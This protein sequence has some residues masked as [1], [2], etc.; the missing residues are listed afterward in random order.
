MT[1]TKEVLMNWKV[2]ISS[3]IYE[4]FGNDNLARDLFIHLLLRT[5]NSD[6]IEPEFYYGK[7]Y[8]LKKGQVIFGKKVY[9]EKLRCSAGAVLNALCR[10]TKRQDEHQI[11]V[12]PS[13]DY[14]VVTII[15][16][17][18]LVKMISEVSTKV[19]TRY[20]PHR[21]PEVTN[22][23][24]KNEISKFTKKNE[25]NIEEMEKGFSILEGVKNEF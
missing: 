5:R 19:S 25:I 3:G 23:S 17:D 20:T 9:S 12:E 6:M 14:T 22:K 24:V 15:S 2:P 4:S 13:N 11:I 7:P 21:R 8:I 10:L 18:K 1:T 16:Y